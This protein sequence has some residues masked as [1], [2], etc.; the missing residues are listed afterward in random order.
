MSPSGE[1]ARL[2]VPMG[3][4]VGQARRARG[5]TQEELAEACSLSPGYIARLERGERLPSPL[6]LDRIARTLEVEVADLW[7]RRNPPRR[8]SRGRQTSVQPREAAIARLVKVTEGLSVAEIRMLSRL[9]QRLRQ[10]PLDKG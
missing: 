4:V 1:L 2:A 3:R 9:V 7:P 6:A 5:W 10:R 8:R